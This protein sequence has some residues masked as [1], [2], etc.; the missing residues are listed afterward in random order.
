MSSMGGKA[1]SVTRGIPCIRWCVGKKKGGEL[2]KKGRLKTDGISFKSGREKRGYCREEERHK[3]FITDVASS[4]NNG[5]KK[6]KV[7]KEGWH[8]DI[9]INFDNGRKSRKFGKEGRHGN[10]FIIFNNGSYKG[11]I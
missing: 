9:F 2:R 1:R 11:V 5:R 6:G 7:Q 4:F 10:L 8:N 3:V